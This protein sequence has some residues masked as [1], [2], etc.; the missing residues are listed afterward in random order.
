[1]FSEVQSLLQIPQE[2]HKKLPLPS[3]IPRPQYHPKALPPFI[4]GKEGLLQM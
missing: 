2:K 3:R 1:M 4:L